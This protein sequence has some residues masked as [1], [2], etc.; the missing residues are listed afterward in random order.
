MP[1]SP[2]NFQRVQHMSNQK[3]T[4]INQTFLFNCNISLGLSNK[5][6]KFIKQ[7]HKSITLGLLNT[8]KLKMW[9]WLRARA[10]L[11]FKLAF[12]RVDAGDFAGC[13][14]TS[15]LLPARRGEP[16]P[17]GSDYH[18]HLK[19]K[20]QRQWVV[21]GFKPSLGDSDDLPGSWYLN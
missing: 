11:C 13:N 14:A 3:I 7:V 5:Y 21:S 15:L 1:H 16:T 12:L 8:S 6:F 10:Y 18:L 2:V 19:Q 17:N 20:I 9:A 4:R